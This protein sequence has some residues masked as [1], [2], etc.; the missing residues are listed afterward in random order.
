[1]VLLRPE[2]PPQEVRGIL[3]RIRGQVDHLTR[4]TEDL[5]SASRHFHPIWKLD[6]RPLALT[7]LIEETLGLFRSSYPDR[8]FTLIAKEKVVELNADGARLN[9]VLTNLLSNATK[10]SRPDTEIEVEVGSMPTK[11]GA[12]FEVRDR[13][14][15]IP[16]SK[17]SALF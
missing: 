9:Q 15:G 8:S 11:Y 7:S 1:L 3:K 17:K 13:G 12:Y 4:I 6:R 10:Y 2:M 5:L 14:V 16:D